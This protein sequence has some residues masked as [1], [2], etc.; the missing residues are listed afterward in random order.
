VIKEFFMTIFTADTLGKADHGWLKSNHHFS[1]AHYYDPK[2]MGVGALRVMNDDTVAPGE[3][4][5]AHPHKDM[6]I[7]SYVI[8]GGLTHKDNMGTQ[9]TLY[10]GE[11][12]YMSA[13]TG[14]IHSEFN[15]ES[16]PLRFLQLWVLPDA[17]GHTPQYGS[18]RFGMEERRG[19]WLHMV[20][21][22]DGKAPIKIH[23]DVNIFSTIIP[24]G[25]SLGFDLEKGRQAYGVL[26]SGTAEIDG[27][28]TAAQDGFHWEKSAHIMAQGEAHILVVEMGK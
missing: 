12:Q 25:D 28:R 22:A 17:K 11:V 10:P 26:I 5:S 21:S 13:G 2:R 27:I 16:S 20:S 8:Q 9:E 24:S 3:G 7:I 6:E 23:Q 1:F 14:V 18:V 4:F 19:K 15:K